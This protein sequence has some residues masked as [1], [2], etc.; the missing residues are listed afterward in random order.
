MAAKVKYRIN[1]NKTFRGAFPEKSNDQKRQ[2]RALLSDP[3]FRVEYGRAIIDRIIE[4]TSEK[5]IDKR[6]KSLGVYTKQ[7]AQSRFG[8]IYGK[9]A[10]ARV[11]LVAS[12]E[13]LAAIQYDTT[14]RDSIVFDFADEFNNDKAHG[15]INGYKNRNPKKRRPFFG[16]PENEESEIMREVIIGLRQRS[17]ITEL[18]EM[19]T[20][21]AELA[22]PASGQEVSFTAFS[23]TD[24][25]GLL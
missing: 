6:G 2:L 7:Y 8:K 11:N 17:F 10:G 4:R 23:L 19:A 16:L 13:M 14:L 20:S 15:H 18:A 21:T 24:I 25:L 12:G 1:L 22:Q 3:T 5:K 9:K